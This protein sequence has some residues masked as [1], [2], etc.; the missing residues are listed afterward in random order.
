MISSSTS[1]LF[2]QIWLS[3][4]S[5]AETVLNTGKAPPSGLNTVD[6][7][8]LLQPSTH[9]TTHL[10]QVEAVPPEHLEKGNNL[11]HSGVHQEGGSIVNA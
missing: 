10:E 5:L 9:S 4:W 3:M 6:V 7:R 8:K 11:E 2:Q 1:L